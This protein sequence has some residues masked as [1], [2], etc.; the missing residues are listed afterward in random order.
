M[1][2]NHQVNHWA[3]KGVPFKTHLYVPE[4]H[5]VTQTQFHEREDEGHVFKVYTIEIC[6]TAV[7]LSLYASLP[8]AY[9][10]AHKNGRPI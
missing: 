4:I 3:E 9:W 10:P 5:P 6:I 7:W 1:E 2:F 8:L